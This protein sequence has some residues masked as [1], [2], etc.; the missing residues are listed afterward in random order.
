MREITFSNVHSVHLYLNSG[1]EWGNVTV[2]FDKILARTDFGY[3]RAG[4]VVVYG[5]V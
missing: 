2:R 5:E 3:G 4:S 1:L